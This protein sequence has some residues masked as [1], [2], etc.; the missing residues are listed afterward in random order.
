L[1]TTAD[2][3]TFN[4]A[5]LAEQARKDFIL[6][7]YQRLQTSVDELQS[8]TATLCAAP[9]PDSLKDVHR[10]FRSAIDAWGRIEMATF[11][12]VAENN[13]FERI[14]FWPDRKGRG[15]RQVRQLI[16]D[17]AGAPITPA[18]LSTMSVAVQGLTALEYILYGKGSAG[19]AE[20]GKADRRCQFA[21][22]VAT[23]LSQ[24]ITRIRASWSDTGAFTKIWSS[25][26]KDNPAYLS[27]SEVTLELVKALDQDLEMV[28][29]R[30][31][32]PALGLTYKRRVRRAVL[33]RS[34]LSLVLIQGNIEGARDLFI[35]GGLAEA[36]A[37]GH[38]N[39]AEAQSEV[40]SLKSEFKLMLRA[41][42]ALAAMP[43]DF[44]NPDIK[45]RL[46][47]I[48]FPLKNLRQQAVQLIKGAAGLSVS[49][50]ASDGD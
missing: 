3:Q 41:T 1:V 28:R 19:L 40:D 17:T 21:D 49:I 8:S 38:A 48:G 39:K 43:A 9:S 31:I 27:G 13:R 6:P 15:R 11:G 5:K 47:A 16:A 12:P 34:K 18:S 20:P 50:N 36:S 23:N 42:S 45:A 29:D 37:T 30:R 44:D 10:T 4:H 26:G 22:A 32:G 14:F 25:P 33:W 2:A 46:V 7:G 35:A 24:I